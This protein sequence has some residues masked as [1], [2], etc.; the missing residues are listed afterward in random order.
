MKDPIECAVARLCF[1]K[2]QYFL[3]IALCTIALTACGGSATAE[4]TAQG[5][6]REARPTFTPTIGAPETAV[7]P[8]PLAANDQ[9]TPSASNTPTEV[10]EQESATPTTT[11]DSKPIV[12][13]NDELVNTRTGPGL[14]FDLV[15]TVA[16]GE[17]F[18]II[19]KTVDGGWWKICCV[20]GQ[21]VWVVNQFVQ[22]DGNVDSVAVISDFSPGSTGGGNEPVAQPPANPTPVAQPT[23]V[24][25]PA[26]PTEPPAPTFGFDLILQ[27]QFPETNVL[28]IFLFVFEGSNALEG[29][30]LRMVHNGV[31]LPTSGTVSIGPIP[32][33]TWP[34]PDGRQR[35]QN[36]KLE[37]PSE[38]PGGTWEAQLTLNGQPVGPVATFNLKDNEPNRELYVRYQKK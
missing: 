16:R 23:P 36:L 22:T 18:D 9:Q 3:L 34:I 10:S 15:D 26:A 28:R 13:I 2:V 31:E 5:P 30:S 32:G 8:V 20:D 24:P 21:Q 25:P 7:Q 14:N 17:E 37:F 19:G 6:L 38:Q 33:L 27:E 1:V 29:Y 4:E 35:L 12:V 11:A